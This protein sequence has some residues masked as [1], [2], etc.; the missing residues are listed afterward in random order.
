MLPKNY[1]SSTDILDVNRHKEEEKIID[2]R[3]D[4]SKL[5]KCIELH[6]LAS[7]IVWLK[8]QIIGGANVTKDESWG[9][10]DSASG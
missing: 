6:E 2:W 9:P 10:D 7:R 1:E 8:Q 5:K 4:N 3:N